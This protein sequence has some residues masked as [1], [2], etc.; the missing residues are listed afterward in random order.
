MFNKIA[1]K[2][3][4]TLKIK[5]DVDLELESAKRDCKLLI[6]EIQK[7]REAEKTCTFEDKLKVK[8]IHAEKDRIKEVIDKKYLDLT[9]RIS[10]D[11]QL[12]WLLCLKMFMQQELKVF[13][14]MEQKVENYAVTNLPLQTAK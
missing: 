3:Q 11:C 8:K 12:E 1:K 7:Q 14:G 5:D 9:S 13:K 10:R 6:R 4:K 2:N